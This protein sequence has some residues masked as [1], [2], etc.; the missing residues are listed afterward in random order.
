M[1]LSGIKDTHWYIS[2]RSKY[3]QVRLSLKFKG[4]FKRICGEYFQRTENSLQV[5]SNLNNRP[6]LAVKQLYSEG[7][8]QDAKGSLKKSRISSDRQ[9]AVYIVGIEVYTSTRERIKTEKCESRKQ[10]V[11]PKVWQRKSRWRTTFFGK[12]K[13][14]LFGLRQY[15]RKENSQIIKLEVSWFGY[16]L[17][18]QD[19]SKVLLNIIESTMN[20]DGVLK[21]HLSISS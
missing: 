4:D 10:E 20:I 1:V 5:E 2:K 19:L 21:E 18:K 3:F 17:L 14:I 6:D 15:T 16:G 9:Q 7:R 12:I 13:L 8:L 11:K